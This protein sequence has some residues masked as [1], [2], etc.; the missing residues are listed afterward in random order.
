M[1]YE[2]FKPRNEFIVNGYLSSP[3]R[4]S[5]YYTNFVNFIF[6]VKVNISATWGIINQ[7]ML[8]EKNGLIL[9]S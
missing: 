5:K 4:A 3:C 1:S 6:F 8:E 9:Q 7:C 2:L